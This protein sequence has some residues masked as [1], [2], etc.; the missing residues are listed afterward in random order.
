M[1]KT[2]LLASLLLAGSTFAQFTPGNEPVIGDASNM[3]LCDSF[4]TNYEG[5]IGSGVTWDYSAIHKINGEMKSLSI[6][7][8]ATTPNAGDFPTSNKNVEV[9]GFFSTYWETSATE[10]NVVGF[11][12]NEPS[13]GEIKAV[14]TDPAKLMDYDFDLND[15]VTDPYAGTLYFDFNGIPLSPATTGTS[16]S[17]VDGKGTLML[18][19]ATTLTDVLRVVTID[20]LNADI[21]LG[22]PIPVVFIRK[23][24]EYYHFATSNLP[25]FTHSTGIMST[26]GNVVGEFTVVL[27]YFEPDNVLAVNN[28]TVANFNVYPNPVKSDFT[29]TGEFTQADAQIINQTGQVVKTISGVTPGSNIEMSQFEN[30]LYFLNLNINGQNHVQKIIKE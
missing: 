2:L 17:K 23:Q 3:F 10:R 11:I 18:N 8:P 26:N 9:Q 25:V 20:T 22:A 7:D 12:Y 16:F 14:F 15:N 1:K 6:I 21:N 29:I 13:F 5:V 24:F 28:T 4:A 19:A 30:G 27:S